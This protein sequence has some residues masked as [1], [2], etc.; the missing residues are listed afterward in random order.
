MSPTDLR[1]PEA[2]ETGLSVDEVR[3]GLHDGTIAGPRARR[4]VAAS[5]TVRSVMRTADAMA[6]NRSAARMAIELL[7][8]GVV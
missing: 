8:A 6:R 3:R 7:A 4:I 2:D 1:L 5:D